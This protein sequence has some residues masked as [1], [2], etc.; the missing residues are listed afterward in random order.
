MLLQVKE[1]GVLVT[2]CSCLVSDVAKIFEVYWMMGKEDSRLPP[3][4][5]NNLSTKYNITT[6]LKIDF[7]DDVMFNTYL[8]VCSHQSIVA[9][10][11]NANTKENT[12]N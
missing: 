3:V 7:D 9:E 12:D 6:P 8:S 1:L 10:S 5:P 2:N 11:S 4:W